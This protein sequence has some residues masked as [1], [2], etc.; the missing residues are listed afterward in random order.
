MSRT[1]SAFEAAFTPDAIASASVTASEVSEPYLGPLLAK[2]G[3]TSFNGGMYRLIRPEDIEDWVR[4]A[5]GAFPSFRDR[6]LPFGIDWLGRLFALDLGR[7]VT[8]SPAVTLLE[9]GTGEALE[10]PCTAESFHE[11]ELIEYREESLA[12]SF[13][14]AWLRAGGTPPALN[15]CVAYRKPLFLGGSDTVE[16]LELTDLHL[17]WGIAEQL[18]RKVRGLPLGTVVEDVSL[19]K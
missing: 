6:L 16:N 11:S 2:W 1:S 8:G 18:I 19:R 10:I 9:P 5:E 7:T 14:E 4:I 3:G 13:L 15:E 17:Y 12:A